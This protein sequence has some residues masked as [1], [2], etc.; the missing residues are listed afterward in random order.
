M[1][2]TLAVS[3]R[4]EIIQKKLMCFLQLFRSTTL[5]QIQKMLSHLK[6]KQIYKIE[7]QFFTKFLVVSNH[8]RMRILNAM[9]S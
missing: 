6:T 2:I 3:L 4:G 7:S 1:Y 5:F 8:Y 9:F